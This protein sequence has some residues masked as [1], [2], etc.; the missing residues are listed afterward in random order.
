M[1][2]SSP[3]ADPDRIRFL[4]P[5]CK[6]PFD[7]DASFA[8]RKGKCPCGE[9]FQIPVASDPPAA[10]PVPETADN[11]APV[12][13]TMSRAPSRGRPWLAAM[14][15]ALAITAGIG[16]WQWSARSQPV[17]TSQAASRPTPRQFP[18]PLAGDASSV[19]QSLT[20][21]LVKTE[22]TTIV[23]DLAANADYRLAMSAHEILRVTGDSEWDRFTAAHADA[24]AFLAEFLGD[25]DW[26]DAY[27]AVGRVPENDSTGLRVLAEIWRADGKSPDFREYFPLSAALASAWSCGANA[28]EL[29]AKETLTRFGS[30]PAGRYAYFK[31]Q[32]KAGMLHPMFDGL[33]SWELTLVVGQRCDD[34]S[35]DWYSRN[36]NIPLQRYVDACWMVQYRGASD[37]GD[38]I[39]GPMFYR[40]W[41]G[42][43]GEGENTLRHGG[44]CGSLSTFATQAA[45]AHG[46]PAYPVGQPGHC[47]YG[48]RFARGHWVGGFGGPDGSA[49]MTIW[50]GNIHYVDLAESVFG[51]DTGLREAMFHAARARMHRALGN[52]DMAMAAMDEALRCSPKHLDLRK[53]EIAMLKARDAAD[54][55]KLLA[56]ARNLLVVFG[57]DS[58]PAIDLIHSFD[59]I[60]LKS[61]EDQAKLD[62][63]ARVHAAAAKSAYSWAWDIPKDVLARE[64]KALASAECRERLLHSAFA[65]C[66]G[67]QYFGNVLEWGITEYLEKDQ[68][69]AFGR[70][71]NATLSAAGSMDDKSL[72]ASFGKIILATE[73]S[74]SISAFQTIA[75]SAVARFAPEVDKL[76]PLDRPAG[77]LVSPGGVIYASSSSWDD[78]VKHLNVLNETGGTIHTQAEVTPSITVQLPEDVELSGVLAI[79]SEGNQGRMKRMRVSRSVDGA[80]WHPLADTPDMPRQ[81]K[82]DAPAGTRARWVKI[83]AVN[84]AA[85]FMHLRNL[86][87]FAKE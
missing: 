48:V 47:A 22:S 42:L 8:G 39:Q 57:N 31:R 58:H 81:W 28:K 35:L 60:F 2:Q 26:M 33:K 20:G 13:T 9:K 52:A 59:D 83:E 37:F 30:H 24:R 45:C 5:G 53:E 29:Q 34:D 18:F 7:V 69:D 86:L 19:R 63:F 55:A 67:T 23:G 15:T 17:T 65:A 21:A 4:C 71:F 75:K 27:L 70:S 36:V 46:I 49:S 14:L 11:P 50:P 61:M 3:G 10:N 44:V 16:V 82:I 6:A 64:Y 84:D 41:S 76:G 74:R 1:T 38:H 62:W 54:P 80:T 66:A 25:Q 40:P 72:R 78:P 43:M 51:D 77:R 73:K 79:K 56:H 12:A 32:H 85:E 87:I 68:G